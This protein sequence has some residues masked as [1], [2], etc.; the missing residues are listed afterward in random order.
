M[1]PFE[2][3]GPTFAQLDLL[4]RFRRGRVRQVLEVDDEQRDVVHLGPDRGYH[5]GAQEFDTC[6]GRGSVC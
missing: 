4:D 1:G 5:L 2:P 3:A 6:E